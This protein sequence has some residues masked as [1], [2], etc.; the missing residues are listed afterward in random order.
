MIVVRLSVANLPFSLWIGRL[1]SDHSDTHGAIHA[2]AFA[3]VTNS[4]LVGKLAGV[5]SLTVPATVHVPLVQYSLCILFARSTYEFV[6]VFERPRVDG[7][8]QSGFASINSFRRRREVED[9]LM[10]C[11]LVGLFVIVIIVVSFLVHVVC[12]TILR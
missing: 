7:F 10:L 12:S 3:I 11:V 5:G 4:S 6:A 8:F 9:R 2:I 1:D